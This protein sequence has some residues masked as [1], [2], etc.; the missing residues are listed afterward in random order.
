MAHVREHVGQTDAFARYVFDHQ[1]PMNSVSDDTDPV[2]EASPFG[3]EIFEI[4][5]RDME[6]GPFRYGSH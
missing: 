3:A 2:V 1:R 6:L 5:I 4:T